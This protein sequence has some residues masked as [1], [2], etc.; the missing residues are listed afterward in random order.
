MM[1]KYLIK[2]IPLGASLSYLTLSYSNVSREVWWEIT[3]NL[4]P[5]GAS[6]FNL[7]PSY[8]IFNRGD[9]GQIEN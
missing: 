6:L 4:I 9:I 2:L 3:I 5:I 8:S 1:G 7:N